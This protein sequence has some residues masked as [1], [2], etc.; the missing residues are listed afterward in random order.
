MR[1]IPRLVTKNV[2]ASATISPTNQP[3]DP[4]TMAAVATSA[5]S[6]NPTLRD[7][8]TARSGAREL[9]DARRGCLPQ[10]LEPLSP[11]AVPAMLDSNRGPP[12]HRSAHRQAPLA[13]KYSVPN[14][15]RIGFF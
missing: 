5:P 4:A 2:P 15:N 7:Y 1:S 14:L 9:A 12:T 3:R 10:S 13:P 11:R 6:P 8:L